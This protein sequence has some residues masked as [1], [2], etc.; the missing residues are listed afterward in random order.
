MTERVV[1]ISHRRSVYEMSESLRSHQSKYLRRGKSNIH[2]V[3]ALIERLKL[4]YVGR[5]LFPW[6]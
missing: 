1:L 3:L 4:K 6:L 2:E 5:N